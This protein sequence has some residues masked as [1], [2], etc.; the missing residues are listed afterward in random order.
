[1]NLSEGMFLCF[2][3]VSLCHEIPKGI[4]DVVIQNDMPQI[5]A[6]QRCLAIN[7][8]LSQVSD[9]WLSTDCYHR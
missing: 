6:Q 4:T 7:T 8:L 3:I 1:M 5:D 2:R 9:V